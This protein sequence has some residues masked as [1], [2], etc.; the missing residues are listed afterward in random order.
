MRI[1][2]GCDHGGYRL[3]EEIKKLLVKDGYEVIDFGTDSEESCDYPD[4]ARLASRSVAAGESDFGFLFCTTGT[5]MAMCANKFKNIRCSL[6]TTVRLA[7]LAREHNNANM[8]AF[9]ASVSPTNL[10]L[11]MIEAFIKTP[12]AGG[13]HEKRVD[14]INAC[15]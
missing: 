3:K 13:R 10:V 14:K 7:E 2:I 9:G 6:P 4:F 8:C 5:G 11:E 15:D 1:A 12:F